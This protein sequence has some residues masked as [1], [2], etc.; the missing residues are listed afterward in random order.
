M[1]KKEPSSAQFIRS[2]A[3]ANR[4]YML[5][6]QRENER[7]RAVLTESE[8]ERQRLLSELT[9]VRQDVVEHTKKS[10]ELEQHLVAV[11][12]EAHSFAERYQALE[13]QNSSLMNLYVA[14]YR[15]HET[16]SRDEVLAV[17][18]EV[19]VNLVG[20]EEHAIFE[21]HGSVP[22]PLALMGITVSDMGALDPRSPY[23]LR[24]IESG[25]P[26]IASIEGVEVTLAG[27]PLS[28]IIPIKLVGNVTGLIV[29]FRLLPQKGAI[30]VV[31]QELFDLLATHAG[32]AL[33]CTKLHH[34]SV[35]V[36]TAARA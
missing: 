2:V 5:D 17:I 23:I 32:I 1:E 15:L 19:V 33:Y 27:R 10:R 4:E 24:A 22:V 14:S 21:L 18:Q 11:E 13:K 16:L 30:D 20:C 35:T 7:L 6:I 3:D 9:A 28:A 31:D 26:F 8:D 29:L 36:R 12:H 25:N 34:Q